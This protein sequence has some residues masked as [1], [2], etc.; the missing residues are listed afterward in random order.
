MS[1]DEVKSMCRTH[2]V[3]RCTGDSRCCTDCKAAKHFDISLQQP[4]WAVINFVDIHS[5]VVVVIGVGISIYVIVYVI[6]LVMR[7]VEKKTTS[8]VKKSQTTNYRYRKAATGMLLMF[9]FLWLIAITT[10]CVS[11]VTSWWHS[12]KD[13]QNKLFSL[14]SWNIFLILASVDYALHFVPTTMYI[15]ATRPLLRTMSF[16]AL[17]NAVGG[18]VLLWWVFVGIYLEGAY[19]GRWL[20]AF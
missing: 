15:L 13:C 9:G 6:L 19:R 20:M 8:N 12:L 1:I 18:I 2:A 4:E 17:V 16:T 11:Y 10:Y 5:S 14:L 3:T 7:R